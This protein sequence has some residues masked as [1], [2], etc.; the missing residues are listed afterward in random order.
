[1]KSISIKKGFAT[2]AGTIS[3]VLFSVGFS[4]AKIPPRP[5]VEQFSNPA[6]TEPSSQS[7]ARV[8]L[9]T[10]T[11]RVYL[12]DTESVRPGDSGMSL[13]KGN[14]IQ[15]GDQS[16]CR[17]VFGNGD[18]LHIGPN[19]LVAVD[20][21]GDNWVTNLWQGAVMAYAMPLLQGREGQVVIQTPEGEVALAAGKFS[22]SV[23][24][25]STRVSVFDNTAQWTEND[26][27]T[28]T[29][30][31]GQALTIDGEE[32]KIISLGPDFEATTTLELSPEIPALQEGIRA[33]RDNDVNAAKGILGQVRSVF[34]YNGAAAY[35][36]GLIRLNEGDLKGA[37]EQW[38]Q[39]VKIDPEG[40]R[41]KGVPRY[42]TVVVGQH[43]KEEAQLAIANEKM[44]SASPPT[45]N[46]IAVHPIQ[47]KGQ[48]QYRAI[49][50]GLTA[51]VIADLAKIPGLKVL[52]REKI[53]RILDEIKLSES[54]LV[55]EDMTVRS[56]RL[57]RAEKLV[58]GDF[59]IEAEGAKTE[60]NNNEANP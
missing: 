32:K 3:L 17:L 22:I 15:T 7:I 50:K 23:M 35:Y 47:S 19:S 43:L 30:A 4:W 53:Q 27:T 33:F 25:D 16:R 59:S 28:I 38:Q 5:D 24:T 46:S 13:G 18:V 39:Y 11:T 52:E 1:M 21:V 55:K 41:E 56:G 49:G 9:L 48:D 31:A 42:L 12:P 6:P 44:L 60:T 14:L 2:L 40:A 54:G 45:P 10:G 51:M 20:Q 37:I 29:L 58:V 26:G 36:L 57:L 34:P 8:E